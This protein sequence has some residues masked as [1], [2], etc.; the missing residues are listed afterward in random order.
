MDTNLTPIPSLADLPIRVD[1]EVGAKLLSR[2]FFKISPRTLE[3]WPLTWRR[4]NGKAHCETAELFDVAEA[5]LSAAPAIMG[6]RHAVT[7]RRAA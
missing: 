6:G 4:L 2:Y 1:R 3:R 5:M 7:Q